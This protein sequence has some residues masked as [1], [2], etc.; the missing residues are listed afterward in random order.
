MSNQ[1]YILNPLTPLAFLPPDIAYQFTISTYVAIGSVGALVWDIL[2]NFN[3]DYQLLFKDTLTFPTAAYFL[4]RFSVLVYSLLDVIVQTAPLGNHCHSVEK[5]ICVFYHIA[6][7]ST[8]LLFFLRVRAVFYRNRL[9]ILFDFLL[10]LAVLG[11]SLTIATVGGA[12]E[13]G[14]TKYCQLEPPKGYISAAPITLTVFDTFVF[15]AVSWHLIS[16]SC[17]GNTNNPRMKGV[18]LGK[19]IPAFSRAVLQNGQVYYLVSVTT[20]LTIITLSFL[21]GLPPI[22]RYMLIFNCTLTNMMACKVFRNIKF[23]TFRQTPMPSHAKG[24]MGSST[25]DSGSRP[26]AVMKK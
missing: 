7:S 19:Y 1:S 20:N 10:W 13:L 11:G 25:K 9:I 5:A 21:S 6:F 3:L 22:F 8:S 15:L 2:L 26:R 4:S 14:P 17:A 23:G 16:T 12:T 24:S 18:L